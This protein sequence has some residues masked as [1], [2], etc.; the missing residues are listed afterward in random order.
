MGIENVGQDGG[1]KRGDDAVA[2]QRAS[3][4]LV[5]IWVRCYVGSIVRSCSLFFD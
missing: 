3:A 5:L 4:Q 2:R 1:V